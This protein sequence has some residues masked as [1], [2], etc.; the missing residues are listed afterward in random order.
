MKLLRNTKLA[1]LGLAR[2]AGLFSAIMA[3]SWRRNRLLILCF[4]GISLDDEHEWEP[5]LYIS[6]LQFEGRLRLLHEAGCNVLPLGEALERLRAGNLGERAV[7]ITFDDGFYDFAHVAWPLLKRFS[8]PATLYLT[9]Y[10][11]DHSGW[12]VFDPMVSYVLWKAR[13][14]TLQWQEVL[15]EE[16]H[17]RGAGQQT[18]NLKLRAY[19][20]RNQLSGQ[21]KNELLSELCNRTGF[22]LEKALHRRILCLMNHEEVRGV[23]SEGAD[24]QLHTHRHRVFPQME[25]FQKDME[26]NRLRIEPLTHRP[27]SH[28]CYPGGYTLASLPDWLRAMGITSATTCELG[29]ATQANNPYY[30]PRLL[31]RATLTDIE[32]EAWLCG[33]SDLLPRR[34]FEPSSTQLGETTAPPVPA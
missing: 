13:N 26:D 25:A 12:P 9:T 2:S 23:A 19:C 14:A 22:D 6:P 4:H 30:L 16:I 7:T 31:D 24:I 27:A 17:L 32:F 20:S 28:F 18:A 8:F 15:G 29:L 11:S 3:S 1:A 10:Y 33:I 21:Q 5:G 34:G